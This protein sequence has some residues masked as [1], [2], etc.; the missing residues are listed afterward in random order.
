MA[1]RNKIEV[2]KL[3]DL[4]LD[5]MNPRLGRSNK[6]PNVIQEEV[7][8]IMRDWS[9]EELAVSFLESGFWIQEALLVVEERLYNKKR[10]VVVEGNRRL[11]ALLY[12]RDAIEGKPV[13][14]RWTE[15][16]KI[17]EPP[18]NLFTEIPFMRADSRK[19]IEAFLG[20]RHVTGIKEWKPAEKAEY[21]A[22]LVEESHMTYEEVMRKI[23]SKTPTVRQN[24]I[25]YRLLLQM[26]DQEDISIEKVEDKF[27]VLYLSLRTAGVQ[28]YLQIDI[29]ADPKSARK[30]VPRDRLEQLAN[31]ALWL[32]G[33]DER[34]P[35]F[36]DSRLVDDFGAILESPKAVAYLERTDRPNFEIAL[37]TA[38][39]DIPELL[40]LI[41][42]A[43]DN[44]ELALTRIHHHTNSE[45]L[46]L[47]IER[48]GADALQLLRI[49]PDIRENLL[50]EER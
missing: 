25:S 32:F 13:S 2:A 1:I 4:C 7:L 21:I 17:K 38:G 8:D 12:L 10:L 34:P 22:K 26:G 24:Y 36:T 33:D 29:K 3:D 11:A 50:K 19:D 27:S 48:F 42:R 43:S 30:P 18:P 16:A 23:G 40:K 37:R 41:D 31:F 28:R 9:L 6:G 35:L 20:Y 46:Q 39:G 5:P 15:I 49:F 47:A 44:V 45:K 14:K